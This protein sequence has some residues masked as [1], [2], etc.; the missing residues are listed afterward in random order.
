[1]KIKSNIRFIQNMDGSLIIPTHQELILVTKM[2]PKFFI[3]QKVYVYYENSFAD[4]LELTIREQK[5][6]IEPIDDEKTM[7]HHKTIANFHSR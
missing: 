7:K 1:M 5:L 6:V 2:T 4:E 3:V